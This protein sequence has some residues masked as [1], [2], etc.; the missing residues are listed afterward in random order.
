MCEALAVVED[1][2]PRGRRMQCVS[3][4]KRSIEY[5]SI[6][7]LSSTGELGD[8]E[9]PATPDPYLPGVSKRQ[10]EAKVSAWRRECRNFLTRC[11]LVRRN[12]RWPKSSAFG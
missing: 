3:G 1:A 10:W 5:V 7:L 11:R 6:Q 12:W 2:D 8:D 4:V 9:R